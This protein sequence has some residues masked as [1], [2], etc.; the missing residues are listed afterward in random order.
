MG[1]AKSREVTFTVCL[2]VR[3]GSSLYVECLP[4]RQGNSLDFSLWTFLPWPLNGPIVGYFLKS[5]IQ[6]FISSTN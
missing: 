4:A 3:E 5:I 2:C 6:Y 1:E